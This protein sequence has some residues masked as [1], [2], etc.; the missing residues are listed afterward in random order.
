VTLLRDGVR[1]SLLFLRMLRYRV[2]LML[3]LFLLLGAAHHGRIGDAG[4]RLA[5]AA[6]ALAASYVAATTVN[7]VADRE[8][9]AINH[10]GDPGRPLV[11]GHAGA[12]DLVILHAISAVI[13][14]AAAG[15]L[16]LVAAALVAVSV[17]FGQM[18]SLPPLRLSYRTHLAPLLL[19]IAYVVVPYGLGVLAA[20]STFTGSDVILL[21]AIVLLFLARIVLKDFR[22]RAGDETY[23]KPT[24]LLRFGV[25]ATCA[26]SLAALVAGNVLLL[27]ALRPALPIAVVLEAS[28]L[29]IV[30]RLRALSVAP[31]AREEQ[32][33]I[34]LG[35]RMGN[36]ILLSVLGWLVLR[37]EG[38]STAES[39][40]L[41]M[42]IAAV[43]WSGFL[44]LLRN[45]A[46]AVIAYKG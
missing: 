36:A 27:A 37:A 35:A 38:A 32:L 28:F 41:V 5:W 3:W 42:V 33:A 1:W 19:A 40:V 15:I 44:A 43:A 22:D 29:A 26:V 18:Y 20:R 23:G 7:D 25:D 8:I 24:L 13:A 31:N 16:G 2:A 4:W 6:V 9:D 21:S 34:G 12:R 10:P 14:V 45:P 30:S 17:L 39:V 46:R 11:S